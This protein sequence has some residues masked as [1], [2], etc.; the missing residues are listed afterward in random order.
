MLSS[1]FPI[2]L[3]PTHF[4]LSVLL[5]LESVI[6]ENAK[7]RNWLWHNTQ[8]WLS[9]EPISFISAVSNQAMVPKCGSW[10]PR[11]APEI[12]TTEES[13]MHSESH[14]KEYKLGGNFRITS[15]PRWLQ[16]RK[17][18]LRKQKWFSQDC[19]ASWEQ[20]WNWIWNLMTTIPC[21]SCYITYVTIWS[22]RSVS[23][24]LL[25]SSITIEWNVGQVWFIGKGVSEKMWCLDAAPGE[26][27]GNFELP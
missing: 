8:P 4:L 26:S 22:I 21:S 17:L 23:Q 5:W 7:N 19:S 18:R 14:K 24:P 16:V 20:N 3:E 6:V 12:L 9:T 13:K 10:A 27:D 2:E 1:V 25:G 15:Q 11:T